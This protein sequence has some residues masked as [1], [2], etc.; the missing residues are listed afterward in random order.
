V[1]ATA[2]SAARQ[3]V[4]AR[5]MTES[6]AGDWK[7]FTRLYAMTSPQLYGVML[8]MTNYAQSCEDL[9]QEVYITVW[10]QAGRYDG[11]KAQVMTWLTAIAR[12]RTLDWLRAQGAGMNQRLV[13]QDPEALD[14]AAGTASPEQSAQAAASETDLEHCL[15]TLNE[16][17]RS[18]IV[19]AFLEGH[20]HAEL[21]ERLSSPL[22]TVKSWVRRGLD[23]LK[24]CLQ[25]LGGAA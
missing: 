12:H 19:L 18:A 3:V 20:S 16:D 9:L 4:L 2:P 11:S 22:G 6:A 15:E 10:K 5:L 24:T 21:A 13:A 25:A 23:G 14:L 1:T 8:R 17:Q 7:A